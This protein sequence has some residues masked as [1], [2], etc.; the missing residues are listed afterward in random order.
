MKKE[1]QKFLSLDEFGSAIGLNSLDKEVIHQKNR[2]IDIL[3]ETRLKL[4]LS[5]V[6]LAKRLTTKQPA[7]A[8]MEAGHVGDVSF[9]FLVRVALAMGLGLELLPGKKVA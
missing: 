3:K 9:D 7:I 1:K 5:Q 8:R 4:K 2:I 6:D